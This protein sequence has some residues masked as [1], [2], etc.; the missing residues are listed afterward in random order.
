MKKL[1][2][3]I[4]MNIKIIKCNIIVK[5]VKSLFVVTAPCLGLLISLINLKKL[6]K[7]TTFISKKLKK[8]WIFYLQGK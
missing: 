5:I 8:R 7:Y 4:V 1:A 2:K 3:N 6:R